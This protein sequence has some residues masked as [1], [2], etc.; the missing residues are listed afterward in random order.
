MPMTFFVLVSLR[1]SYI[2]VVHVHCRK[3]RLKANVSKSAVMVFARESVDGPWKWGEHILPIL[4]KYTYLG[5]VLLVLVHCV[6][7][8]EKEG[9]SV[10]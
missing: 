5:V 1:I 8:W 7:Q 10:A 6:R 2:D 4:S 3:W 9:R